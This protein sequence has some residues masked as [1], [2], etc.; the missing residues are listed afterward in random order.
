MHR[1][2]MLNDIVPEKSSP[3]QHRLVALMSSLASFMS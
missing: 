1:A 3:L 2:D